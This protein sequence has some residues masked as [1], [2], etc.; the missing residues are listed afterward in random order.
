MSDSRVRC[1]YYTAEL[2]IWLKMKQLM[3]ASDMSEVMMN[4]GFS[5]VR[6]LP[7]TLDQASPW[8]ENGEPLHQDSAEHAP[9][10]PPYKA[11]KAV[12]IEA[13]CLQQ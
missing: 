10:K 2:I 4:K 5:S 9:M 1:G 8:L 3:L 12:F 11:S 6:V 7:S 13:R